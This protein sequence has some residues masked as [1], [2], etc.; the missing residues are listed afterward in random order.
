MPDEFIS[1]QPTPAVHGFF[2]TVLPLILPWLGIVSVD[3]RSEDLD[4]LRSLANRRV[5]L[6]P[7]HPTNTE[8]A[9]LFHLSCAVRQPFHYLACR[10]TFDHLGGLWG[11]VIRRVGAFSVVRGT[12][13]RASFRATR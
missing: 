3:Y 11:K 10:E 4:L 12:V 5:L 2:Q 6:T 9:L 1:A 8:P 7:N 13:D